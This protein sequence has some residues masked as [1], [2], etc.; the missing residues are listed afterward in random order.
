MISCGA[1]LLI[2]ALCFYLGILYCNTVMLTIGYALLLLLG[3]SLVELIYRFFTLKCYIDVPI[4]M[5]EGGRPIQAVIKVRNKGFLPAG[6]VEVKI[7]CRNMF[8]K[9]GKKL[10]ISVPN[11]SVGECRHS[12]KIQIDGAGCHDILLTRMKVYSVTGLVCLTRKCKDFSSVL[13][14][15]QIHSAGVQITEG[16][17]NFLGDADVYD[18]FRPGHDSGEIFEIRNYRE[19][20]KLQS[21]HWKLSAKMDELMVKENSLPKACAVVLLLELHPWKKHK[22]KKAVLDA[23]AYL[24][25]VASMS[26]ALMDAKCPHFV[27]WY[28]REKEELRRI[29][30]DD[31]ESFYLFLN[32]YLREVVPTEKSMREEYRRDYRNEWYLYDITINE[33]MELYKNGEFLTKLDEKKIKDECE[34][35]EIIL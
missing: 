3:V 13:I 6:K 18:D 28:S 5:S 25:L 9:K 20:D 31:E 11:V 22:A 26:F 34:K 16:V 35:L 2:V 30:V 10:K 4:S 32:A 27:A 12:V 29:R 1:V 19:K 7:E 24:E 8:Q 21:I 14:M 17:R 15:P 33:K 23:N